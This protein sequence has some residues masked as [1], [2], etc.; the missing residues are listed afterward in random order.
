MIIVRKVWETGDRKRQWSR[1]HMIGK[2]LFKQAR[3]GNITATKRRG[4]ENPWKLVG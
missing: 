2:V 3:R 4:N 1:L